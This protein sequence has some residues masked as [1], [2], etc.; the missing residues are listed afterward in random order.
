MQDK[1]LTT[2]EA[3]DIL[4]TTPAV[5]RKWKALGRFPALTND[6]GKGGALVLRG[7]STLWLESKVMAFAMTSQS[8]T[9]LKT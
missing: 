2:P 5:I 4:R 6:V 1:L 3:A 8:G 7:R 9:A